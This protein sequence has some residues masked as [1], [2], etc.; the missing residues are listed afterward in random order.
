MDE[1]ISEF[2]GELSLDKGRHNNQKEIDDEESTQ[3]QN[4]GW[5]SNLHR[6]SR[7]GEKEYQAQIPDLLYHN[8]Q[9]R[10]QV[11]KKH[12]RLYEPYINELQTYT[13]RNN[14]SEYEVKEYLNF[15]KCISLKDNKNDNEGLLIG[16]PSSD[17]V[18][19][20][21]LNF[22]AKCDYQVI[23]AKF[24]LVFPS[25]MYFNAYKSKIQ[26]PVSLTEQEM[27]EK[28]DQ[29]VSQLQETKLGQHEKWKQELNELLETRN[30]IQ[31]IH[32]HLEAGKLLRYEIPDYIKEVFDKAQKFSKEL[33]KIMQ[34]RATLDEL[35]QKN[36]ISLNE[37]KIITNEMIQFEQSIQ[38]CRDWLQ[39][40]EPYYADQDKINLKNL[41]GFI[42]EYKS[43]PLKC[44]KFE[45]RFKY[46]YE[47]SLDLI[48]KIPNFSR[49]S[50][51]RGTN[52]HER[53]NIKEAIKILQ[54]IQ[55]LNVYCEE[56]DSFECALIITLEKINN[57]QM[58]LNDERLVF[59][60]DL[61]KQLMNEASELNFQSPIQDQIQDLYTYYKLIEKIKKQIHDNSKLSSL[62][63]EITKGKE[64]GFQSQ[65]L[66]QLEAQ[67]IKTI[68]WFKNFE[69]L[70]VEKKNVPEKKFYN[71]FKIDQNEYK[72]LQT[73]EE[74]KLQS[75]QL[76]I[77][78]KSLKEFKE[79]L[80]EIQNWRDNWNQMKNLSFEF[81]KFNET[82]P[83]QIDNNQNTQKENMELEENI[84]NKQGET[85][86]LEKFKADSFDEL[87]KFIQK[88]LTYGIQTPELLESFEY[89]KR[90]VSWTISSLSYINEYQA[91]QTKS[92]ILPDNLFSQLQEVF[93]K[94]KYESE[95]NVKNKQ[96]YEKLDIYLEFTKIPSF[97]YKSQQYNYLKQLKN[98]VVQLEKEVQE[99]IDLDLEE[100]QSLDYFSVLETIPKLDEKHKK[101]PMNNANIKKLWNIYVLQKWGRE[102]MLA[103]KY[104]NEEFKENKNLQELLRKEGILEFISIVDQLAQQLQKSDL[105]DFIDS[106]KQSWTQIDQKFGRL[107][108]IILK[109][110]IQETQT[111]VESSQD[112]DKWTYQKIKTLLKN[113]Q[114]FTLKNEFLKLFQDIQSYIDQTDQWIT[115]FYT[116]TICKRII[117]T[118][119]GKKITKKK[120]I[121]LDDLNLSPLLERK[122]SN[123]DQL[124]ENQIS[125]QSSRYIGAFELD[126]QDNINE[127][128][129]DDESEK[130]QNDQF[131][132][133]INN[134][135]LSKNEKN[136]TENQEYIE[137]DK[138]GYNSAK[139]IYCEY[140]DDTKMDIE[141]LNKDTP[142]KSNSVA[143]EDLLDA[144]TTNKEEES[145][146]NDEKSENGLNRS[147]Y[148][149]PGTKINKTLDDSENNKTKDAE[150][151]LL[152]KS[153]VNTFNYYLSY[154]MI[155]IQFYQGLI[156]DI[157]NQEMIMAQNKMIEL[158]KY[159]IKAGELLKRKPTLEEMKSYINRGENF[160]CYI[161][162]LSIMKKIN[163]WANQWIQMARKILDSISKNKKNLN[164]TKLKSKDVLPLDFCE[165][166][167][168]LTFDPNQLCVIIT[169]RKNTESNQVQPKTI[170]LKKKNESGFYDGDLESQI[171]FLNKQQQAKELEQKQSATMQLKAGPGRKPT[172]TQ[173]KPTGKRNMPNKYIKSNSSSAQL[174][175]Q[176]RPKRNSQIPKHLIQGQYHLDTPKLTPDL[177]NQ[178]PSNSQQIQSMKL[179]PVKAGKGIKEAVFEKVK[180]KYVRKN[181]IDTIAEQPELRKKRLISK[182]G[183]KQILIEDRNMPLQDKRLKK[184]QLKQAELLQA[185]GID[186]EV[187]QQ[188]AQIS[189]L[190]QH[191]H[192]QVIQEDENKAYCICRGYSGEESIGCDGCQDWF[193]FSCIGLKPQLGNVLK[194][195]YC[196]GCCKRFNRPYLQG[197][198]T[199]FIWDSTEKISIDQFN[200]IV[201]EGLSLPLQIKEIDLI[202]ELKQK[203]D[204]QLLEMSTLIE[205]GPDLLK[206]IELYEQAQKLDSDQNCEQVEELRKQE[207]EKDKQLFQC[208]LAHF[209]FPIDFPQA[210]QLLLLIQRRDFT[211]QILRHLYSNK[212]PL[213]EQF[214]NQ[215]Q[216]LFDLNKILVESSQDLCLYNHLKQIYENSIELKNK[217]LQL[218]KQQVELE[219]YSMLLS[220][221]EKKQLIIPN[222]KEHKQIVEDFHKWQSEAQKLINIFNSMNRYSKQQLEI[223]LKNL[224]DK[225]E[226]RI[227]IKSKL[228][229]NL[230]NIQ[231]QL[232]LEPQ[233]NQQQQ[234]QQNIAY[235]MNQNM[236]FKTNAMVH[237]PPPPYSEQQIQ[238]NNQK[239]IRNQILNQMQNYNYDNSENQFPQNSAE[240]RNVYQQNQR[241]PN[242]IITGNE[243]EEDEDS[244]KSFVEDSNEE[245]GEDFDD[246][247]EAENQNN[248]KHDHL[249]YQN[250]FGYQNQVQNMQN[251]QDD[252][253]EE[254]DGDEEED[255]DDEDEEE[256]E[257]GDEDE[258][259]EEEEE[260]DQAQ[261]EDEDGDE[262]DGQYLQQQQEMQTE[263]FD[264]ENQE[265]EDDEEEDEEQEDE[266]N[267]DE[268]EAGDYE[269][270]QEYDENEENQNSYNK[271]K[272][273][274]HFQEI[275][276]D[277]QEMDQE[278]D[279][280][281]DEENEDEEEEENEEEEED[282][283]EDD[284]EDEEE[285]DE[286]DANGQENNKLNIQNENKIDSINLVQREQQY[287][288][289]KQIINTNKIEQNQGKYK[290]LNN[291]S[292]QQKISMS[293]GRSEDNF[294]INIMNSNNNQ[295]NENNVNPNGIKKNYI[296]YG[297]NFSSNNQNLIQSQNGDSHIKNSH[298]TQSNSNNNNK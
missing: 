161:P 178:S 170:D 278:N 140:N 115:N 250:G 35:E 208:Y 146:L 126:K 144:D 68:E 294:Q 154:P 138:S 125:R 17:Q 291:Q 60:I 242:A 133:D 173:L 12:K 181:Q 183:A 212:L 69:K 227:L 221:I 80:S 114:N 2:Q 229:T 83:Q 23:K 207:E 28:I 179:T 182:D 187:Q 118:K 95:L 205:R 85:Q 45:K 203:V 56:F 254:E 20:N 51:T 169:P 156:R 101:L 284:E 188:I 150:K 297:E 165:E 110:P 57:L 276:S 106:C 25:L 264:Q 253:E 46:V 1:E 120:G 123:V 39:R 19:A 119:D 184:S 166:K 90:G 244:I 128:K 224:I 186:A 151:K 64:K 103:N 268:E 290:D 168:V 193:H 185:N 180:R 122:A 237:P 266:D 36:M 89:Y 223:E 131:S 7:V 191:S 48:E 258:D 109:N 260:D 288:D 226:T 31:K 281:V 152:K 204:E 275:G 217:L 283:E 243:D 273:N 251:S 239:Q 228:I 163:K 75:Q 88:G 171:D 216:K 92:D 245:Y 4:K 49:I 153:K 267:N 8:E 98:D 55:K 211:R 53:I 271:L 219:Q 117:Y 73:L 256:E 130:L 18:E 129:E 194:K 279:D 289:S 298:I 10:I 248:N 172:T 21:A 61:L 158:I 50:K 5:L 235:Q 134:N 296:Y 96:N 246:E 105:Q 214:F 124:P 26:I 249:F 222:L 198:K 257:E 159:K 176:N 37:H 6:E 265:G 38:R 164:N 263:A 233:I 160:N 59:T 74:M 94:N 30:Q 16:L 111:L 113:A 100:L 277:G 32:T 22:L 79:I 293:N 139:K 33:K 91:T 209:G 40:L 42:N 43:L 132:A 175:N 54:Q 286:E 47:Q 261:A 63:E 238:I 236:Q 112:N 282:E 206:I 247:G 292:P 136:Y 215:V 11:F 44:D 240:M 76:K 295:Y 84:S 86:N 148:S 218:G 145:N 252:N 108:D 174:Q 262:Q 195:Y 197:H 141:N 231:Q 82:T 269:E 135:E 97:C 62:L 155:L 70:R 149:K 27:Q 66:D 190:H 230:K 127:K 58:H 196:M 65:E 99:I 270:E 201:K 177:P 202:L 232:Q 137:E 287:I 192:I 142:Y 72:K 220:Q 280:E 93:N 13:Y 285:L 255:D 272:Q 107:L 104:I 199:E 67:I 15:A 29:Y 234:M 52:N 116:K 241:Y 81:E 14:L 225:Y 189:Q 147:Y 157:N 9:Q 41:S 24:Y 71:N 167:Y 274:E 210:D 259:E 3:Q 143:K 102:A 213:I 77:E 78:E 87:F 200:E 162:E 34:D 121:N